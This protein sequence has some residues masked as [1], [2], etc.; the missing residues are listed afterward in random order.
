MR[1]A[2]KRY[3]KR[4]ATEEN[5]DII[6]PTNTSVKIIYPNPRGIHMSTYNLDKIIH[7]ALKV[8]EEH[9]EAPGA[10]ARW[11][12]PDSNGRRNMG[13]T[14]YGCADAANALYTLGYFPR[15][16]AERAAFIKVLQDMQKPDGRFDEATHH[17]LHATAHCIAAL[18]LFDAAPNLPLTYHMKEFGTSQ[19]V[20]AFLETRDWSGNP[21]DQSHQGAGFYAAMALACDMPLSWHDAYF[22]W[23]AS[24]TDSQ[25]GIGIEGAQNGQKPMMHHLAGWFHY[26]FNHI[27][28]HRP[29]PNAEKCVD[30]LIDYYWH[31]LSG[32]TGFGRCIGFSEIDWIF[33]LNRA[34]MQCGHRREEAKACIRHFAKGYISYLEDDIENVYKTKFDDL[35][36]LFGM[37]CALA[38][39]Q[40]ALPGEIR[41]SRPLKNVMDR[42]PFI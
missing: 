36:G 14:E 38:E 31:Y 28:A 24:H 39:L 15:D 30:S 20:V 40:I 12:I 10:Y 22:D 9:K 17:T 26:M 18:E 2:G 6:L 23:I 42:R 27:Y 25:T 35:H 3:S 33:L 41:A 1:N 11:R 4:L 34:S 19:Q 37:T 5:K 16:I 21:W 7:Y 13:V 29:I 8:I 32:N